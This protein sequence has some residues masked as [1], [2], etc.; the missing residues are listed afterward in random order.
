MSET[1]TSRG[2]R[3]YDPF[4]AVKVAA[5]EARRL[6]SALKEIGGSQEFRPISLACERLQ[7]GLVTFEEVEGKE[8]ET[9]NDYIEKA[10]EPRVPVMPRNDV[11]GDDTDMELELVAAGAGHDARQD[12]SGQEKSKEFT[13]PLDDSHDS[14][15]GHENI[16]GK[17]KGQ[18]GYEPDSEPEADS[19]LPP[20]SPETWA[21]P[22][23]H[24]G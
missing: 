13:G 1:R 20:T 11:D 5:A 3:D 4:L 24:A 14:R 23:V 18:G 2:L 6:N 19:P 8:L 7:A 21:D 9:S 22:P 10:L 16:A 17:L 15:N 12:H